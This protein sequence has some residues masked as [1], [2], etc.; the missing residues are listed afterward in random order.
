MK[1]KR[2]AFVFFLSNKL[3]G[4]ENVGLLL[5]FSLLEIKSSSASKT[6]GFIIKKYFLPKLVQN[7]INA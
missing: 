4:I 6:I 3:N 5:G 1:L 2:S 7:V